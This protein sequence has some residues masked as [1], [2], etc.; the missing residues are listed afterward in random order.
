M[1][2]ELVQIMRT[3]NVG[4]VRESLNRAPRG[5]NTMIRHVLEG[6]SLHLK[7]NPEGADDLNAM[8]TWITCAKRPLKLEEL[9]ALLKINSPTGD[10]NWWLERTLR[11]QFAS[12]FMLAREDGLTTAELQRVT[13]DAVDDETIF[14]SH[15]A[16]TTVSFCHASIGDFFRNESEVKGVSAE[17]CPAIGLDYHEAQISVL[18]TCLAVLCTEPSSELWDRAANLLP[19]IG[20]YWIP[21]MSSV[22]ISRVTPENKTFIRRSLCNILSDD[23][24]IA[25]VAPYL[26]WKQFSRENVDLLAK[27]ISGNDVLD[28]LDKPKQAWIRPALENCEKFL[29]PSAKFVAGQWLRGH[30]ASPRSSALA[31]HAYMS[32]HTPEVEPVL[33]TAEKIIQAAK[34]ADMEENA[35]W[36]VM[37]V[38]F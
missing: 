3:P 26:D 24:L 27:W 14:D 29:L 7:D 28:S 17:N 8:L 34:W 22:D 20:T 16:T 12:I 11:V 25:R 6:F 1:L 35:T 18:K 2:K 38:P 9:D 23:R 4:R 31:V 37:Y 32:L 10:G 36:H 5:L 15:P 21:S 13:A 30:S 33:D 19:Y